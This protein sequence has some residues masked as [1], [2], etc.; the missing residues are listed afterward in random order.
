MVDYQGIGSLH[1]FAV[2][3]RNML[4]RCQKPNNN[5]Y[6]TYGERGIQV[7]AEWQ[8]FSNFYRDMFS[9][10]KQGLQLDR[11]D[12]HRGYSKENCQWLS[13]KEN[14]QKRTSSK[15]T[16]EQAA[17]IKKRYAPGAA[18]QEQLAKEFGVSGRM[19]RYIGSGDAW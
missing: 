19:I 4:A 12:L 6:K 15:L 2:C 7:S 17:E 16:A 11:I 3:W 9:T 14:A 8:Q 18:Y 10:W 1:P 5:R 13:P